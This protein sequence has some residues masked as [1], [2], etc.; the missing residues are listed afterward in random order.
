VSWIERAITEG[1]KKVDEIEIFTVE[2]QSITAEL[3]GKSIS[4]AKEESS[5]GICIRT[6]DKGRIGASSTNNPIEWERCLQA[7]ISAGKLVSP[8]EW[9][10][11]PGQQNFP[12]SKPCS[13]PQVQLGP[14]FLK[15]II[16]GLI[17]GSKQY[18]ADITSGGAEAS[19]TRI[20]LENSNGFQ[21][22]V[23]Y[24]DNSCSLE[25]IHESSTGN[26]FDMSWEAKLD[27]FQTGKTAAF[28]A[29][30]SWKGSDINTGTYDIVLSPMALGE[31]IESTLIPA[32]SGKNVH[33]GRSLLKDKLNEEIAV[34]SLKV[35]DLPS[36]TEGLGS[37]L[38]DTEG[39]PTKRIDFIK[40]GALNAFA[41]DIRT[42]SR[43]GKVSTGSAV[44]SGASG[45]PGIGHHNLLVEG[46]NT[47]VL[48][49]PAVFIKSV[50][51]AHTANPMSGDF[52]VELSN[53]FLAENGELTTPVRKAM[54][55]GNVFEM[56]K[57]IQ[58]VSKERKVIGDMIL[59]S[60]RIHDQTV[61]GV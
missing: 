58:G 57:V 41:Y 30:K 5:S 37:V 18:N 17:E 38:W 46:R 11:L 15:D 54:L 2:G 52:S 56:L 1:L 50:V 53:A 55:A 24:T 44:R 32:L 22:S 43:Y 61:I 25:T 16:Y 59:P 3:R 13:D 26:E 47:E 40:N 20:S 49:E 60:V 35:Y 9:S 36:T 33:A 34:N 48:E 8:Q 7:A 14:A 19:R 23:D 45:S 27:P 10:G 6:I 28:Y 31:L 42:A 21:A 4:V 51:G 12:S 29:E 39:T